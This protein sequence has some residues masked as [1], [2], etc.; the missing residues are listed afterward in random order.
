[1]EPTGRR[2]TVSGRSRAWQAL[3]R[4]GARAIDWC[5]ETVCLAS[6]AWAVVMAAARPRHWRR[7]TRQVFA[8]QLLRTGANTAVLVGL[9]A[10]LVGI[11]VVMQAQLWLGKVGQT[12]WLGPLLVVVIVRELAPL[13]TNLTMIGRNGSVITVELA[14]MTV[15][16]EVRMLDALGVDPLIYLIMPR[17]AAMFVSTFCLML[18]FLVVSFAGG[19]L[20]SLALGLR[21]APPDLFLNQVLRACSPED[22]LNLLVTGLLP[23][24]LTGVIC[25]SEGLNVP[26]QSTAVPIAARRALSRSAAGLFLVSVPASLLTYL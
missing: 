19:Y 17:V 11:L 10:F 16:G 6:L 24:L 9:V 15:A 1:M 26:A 22:L 3:G 21:V 12:E 5:G 8:Q 2:I 23:S 18:L 14:N 7:T 20:F 4:L 13:L 25:C